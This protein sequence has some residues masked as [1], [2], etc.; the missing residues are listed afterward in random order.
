[1][2]L[3]KYTTIHLYSITNTDMDYFFIFEPMNNI[4][5]EE[6]RTIMTETEREWQDDDRGLV[7]PEY[8]C[9][10]LKDSG[11]KCVGYLT[12]ET[13]TVDNEYTFVCNRV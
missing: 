1:M 6:V 9:Y 3:E 11:V 8:I 13:H 2:I 12:N 5:C 7:L 4:Q 10:C